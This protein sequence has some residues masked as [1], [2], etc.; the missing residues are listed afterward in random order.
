VNPSYTTIITP[1]DSGRVAELR[2]HLRANVAPRFD[3]KSR[4]VDYHPDFL[5]DRIN[6]LHFCSF[7]ILEQDTEDEIPACLVFEATFDGSREEFLNELLRVAPGG[8]DAV[9]QYCVGY[10]K[11]GVTV[12]Q[13]VKEFLIAHD[14]GTHT[15]FIGSHG[16]SVSQID[17]ESRLRHDLVTFLAD[18]RR[19]A[20][21][22][23]AT[24]ADLQQLVQNQFV[25]TNPE[26]RWAEDPAVVPW[27]VKYR[28][29]TAVVAVVLAIALACVLGA[30]VF[31]GVGLHAATLV[32]R[33]HGYVAGVGKDLATGGP[34][35]L[36]LLGQLGSWLYMPSLYA[37]ITLS[38]AWFGVRLMELRIRTYGKNP[39]RQTFPW[40]YVLFLAFI[41]RYVIIALLV[42]FAALAIK[43]GG[44]AAKDAQ[45]LPGTTAAVVVVAGIIV[46]ALRFWATKL[47]LQ[48]ELQPLPWNAEALRRCLLDVTRFLQV[49]AV[50]VAVLAV[51][52]HIQP[53]V[54]LGKAIEPW[55]FAALVAVV[56]ATTGFL[57]FYFI[58][59]AIAFGVRAI[60]RG[61]RKRF[62]KAT[63]LLNPLRPNT[64]KFAREEGGINRN[65][66][67]LA[68]LT[69]VKPGR[70]RNWLLRTTLLVINLFSRFWFNVG[71]LGGIPTIL[72]ARWV[73][74]DNGRR[75][76]FLDNYSGAWDS[77]L[78]E[79]IDMGAVK[80]LN[81]IWTNTFV[82]SDDRKQYAFPETDYYFW[83]GAQAARPFK[84]YVRQS[85]V[86]TLVW[87]SAYRTLSIININTNT[88][89]R[90]ALFRPMASSEIDAIVEHL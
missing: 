16:R 79:F 68:S 1:I 3:E 78:D 72:S 33:I 89:I 39:R 13:F 76:L 55:I 24:M 56:Y 58:V 27:Q 14:V 36:S 64:G 29:T 18:R 20:R 19:G 51:A 37:L 35:G 42:G 54:S 21:A 49:V 2:A 46:L 38:L 86:E 66:N 40:R 61:D 17:R 53:L 9:Y 11:S 28:K 88:D 65:Q 6:G 43:D 77:Y 60:E 81:G 5:F 50:T 7:V 8:V 75:L 87:Y 10:P 80:G 44:L 74:I 67:H 47:K 23:P 34:Y 30:L 83:Q 70:L 90:Q 85:Q 57:V 82:K 41:A 12:P 31:A 71:E 48:V 25:R 62:A 59:A 26:S 22:M 15:L 52:R 45:H 32:T 63:G 73:L 69:Y 84:A 4:T